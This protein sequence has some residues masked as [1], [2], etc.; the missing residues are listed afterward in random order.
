MYWTAKLHS[1]GSRFRLKPGLAPLLVQG[2][3]SSVVGLTLM[4]QVRVL[5]PL[6]VAQV[7]SAFRFAGMLFA[8]LLD[9]LEVLEPLCPRIPVVE[10]E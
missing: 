7:A 4:P 9:K 10:S 3:T 5:L 1:G 8:Q 2:C 6:A